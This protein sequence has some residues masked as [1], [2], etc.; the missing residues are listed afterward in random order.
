MRSDC[1]DTT[2]GV[3]TAREIPKKRREE[4]ENC[5]VVV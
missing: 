2:A 5:M 3:A 4:V 1:L